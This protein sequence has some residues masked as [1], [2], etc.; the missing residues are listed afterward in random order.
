LGEGGRLV[1]PGPVRAG[2]PGP[3]QASLRRLE[4]GGADAGPLGVPSGAGGQMGP[5][6][7]DPQGA[8]FTAWVQHWKS[9][10]YRNWILPPAAEFGW[11]GEV[12]LQFVVDRAGTVTEVRL[13]RSSGIAAYDRAARNALTADRLLPLPAD[14]APATLTI[15]V[16][17]L[18]NAR[19]GSERSGR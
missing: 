13:V 14:Y 16:G 19:P 18:Y 2:V 12:D 3:I 11:S 10:T 8:D 4:A 1:A 6:F 17:F 7:F 9:E 15:D 5:L